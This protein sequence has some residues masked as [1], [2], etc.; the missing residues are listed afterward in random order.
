MIK[1]NYTQEIQEHKNKI[2]EYL[3]QIG[4]T[5][6]NSVND[7]EA[8]NILRKIFIQKKYIK[9]LQKMESLDVEL[10]KNKNNTYNFFVDKLK[11]T[12]SIKTNRIKR[13]GSMVW[14]KIRKKTL[15]KILKG[16]VEAIE[17]IMNK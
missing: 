7:L 12:F 13:P 10:Y 1:L 6:D 15:E 16:D 11:F 9:G 14:F 4:S 3:N 2:D 5:N 17:K 8:Q